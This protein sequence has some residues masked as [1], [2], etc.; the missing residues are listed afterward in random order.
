MAYDDGVLAYV[1]ATLPAPRARVLEVGAGTGWLTAA[2]LDQ[3]FDA[4]AIDPAG[5]APAVRPVALADLDEPAAS[6]DA[7]VAITALHH[8][9]PLAESLARLAALVRP[10][11]LLV[12]D[13]FDV[14]RFDDRAARWRVA[15]GGEPSGAG[16]RSDLHPVD[17]LCGALTAAGFDI[18]APVRG[19][20]LYRWSL[21]PG[22]RDEEER[23]IGAGELPA[24]GARF[25]AVRR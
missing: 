25:V 6:F 15:H 9:E 13:E 17:T 20:Y 19:A 12:V 24:T 23:L 11:G 4:V 1:C 2:L 5:T 21:P 16:D 10:G 3:G 14:A 22:L 8:V 7:A 18:G